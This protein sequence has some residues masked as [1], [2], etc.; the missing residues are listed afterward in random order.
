MGK[1]VQ[2][3][4][5]RGDDYMTSEELSGLFHNYNITYRVDECR[6]VSYKQH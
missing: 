5:F 6:Q 3:A 2:I 1:Y 4:A